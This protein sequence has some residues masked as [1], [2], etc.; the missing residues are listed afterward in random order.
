MTNKQRK[1]TRIPNA[2]MV[3]AHF[4]LL[5]KRKEHAWES[6]VRDDSAS[7]VRTAV[8]TAFM[9]EIMRI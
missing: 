4:G 8:A 7:M 6:R 1:L 9:K 3:H 2:F 5:I